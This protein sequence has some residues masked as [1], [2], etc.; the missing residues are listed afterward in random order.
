MTTKKATYDKYRGAHK[1]EYAARA[2]CD[3]LR[4]VT[5]NQTMTIH[6]ADVCPRCKSGLREIR[7]EPR[8][9]RLMVWCLDC[10]YFVV[11]DRMGR[12]KTFADDSHDHR[13]LTLPPAPSPRR[14]LERL[15]FNH[16][17]DIKKDSRL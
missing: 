16:M 12:I 9:I 13:P 17:Q 2:L 4:T 11:F 7:M 8:F 15:I 3:L 1:M 6:S 5:D 14:P 10:H